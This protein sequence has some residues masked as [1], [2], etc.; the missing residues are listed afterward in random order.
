MYLKKTLKFLFFITYE[1][2]Y[3][4]WLSY[5]IKNKVRWIFWDIFYGKRIILESWKLF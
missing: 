1:N 4:F 5:E 2:I 3:M